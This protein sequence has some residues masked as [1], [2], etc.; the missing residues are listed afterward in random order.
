MG[1]GGGPWDLTTNFCGDETLDV[2]AAVFLVVVDALGDEG[3]FLD[4]AAG[5][6]AATVE[7]GA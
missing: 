2:D 7:E 3:L 1:R 5:G 4:E 6:A